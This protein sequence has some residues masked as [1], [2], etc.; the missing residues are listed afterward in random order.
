MDTGLTIHSGDSLLEGAVPPDWHK[1]WRAMNGRER[2]AAAEV[3]SSLE[4]EY[5]ERR[6]ERGPSLS[7]YMPEVNRENVTER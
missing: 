1:S 2:V 6:V 7:N 5:L 3:K 4:K